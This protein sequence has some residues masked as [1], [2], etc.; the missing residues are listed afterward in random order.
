MSAK[1]KQELQ[2]EE[3][4]GVAGRPAGKAVLAVLHGA[5]L[6]VRYRD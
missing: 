6:L 1:E 5:T 2:E 4:D 3:G